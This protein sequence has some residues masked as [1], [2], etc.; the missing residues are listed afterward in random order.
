MRVCRI[1]EIRAEIARLRAA[2]DAKI[3]RLE[4]EIAAIRNEI[5]E[6]AHIANLE[7]E[8]LARRKRKAIV[9]NA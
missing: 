1:K 4:A 7:A 5:E 8:I 6:D 3:A 9:S 2:T